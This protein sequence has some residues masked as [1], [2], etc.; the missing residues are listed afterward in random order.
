MKRNSIV[1]LL[2][3]FIALS[4]TTITTSMLPSTA[5]ADGS[6]G[7]VIPP[8][9][10][11]DDSTGN[12]DAFIPGATGSGINGEAQDDGGMGIFEIVIKSIALSL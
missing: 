4:A 3:L 1:A 12:G 5:L 6:G 8:A 9:E 11:G 7:T 2:I 10:G